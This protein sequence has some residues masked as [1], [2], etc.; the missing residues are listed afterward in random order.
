[1]I[2]DDVGTMIE[3]EEEEPE[4]VQKEKE[5]S[6]EEARVE[7]EKVTEKKSFS[8]PLDDA[9]DDWMLEEDMGTMVEEA[10]EPLGS[11]KGE[12]LKE[13]SKKPADN[14]VSEKKLPADKPTVEVT[15]AK[16]PIEKKQAIEKGEGQTQKKPKKGKNKKK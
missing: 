16:E 15:E 11:T 3:D 14:L 10:E 1:M 4:N 12:M 8:L 9:S 2:D 13:E 7:T 6:S 5:P